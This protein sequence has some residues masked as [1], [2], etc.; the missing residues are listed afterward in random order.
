MNAEPASP[1]KLDLASHPIG[2]KY[3]TIL[4]TAVAS[5]QPNLAG[6]FLVVSWGCGTAC[7]LFAIVNL[8]TGKIWH[9]PSLILTRGVDSR[10]DSDLI[11]LNP[12]GDS[13]AATVATTYSLWKG[14]HLD[15][16]CQVLYR[17]ED[18]RPVC[19]GS[20]KKTG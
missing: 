13:F 17:E 15:P 5:G 20:N 10:A 12:V 3:R 1:G 4:R 2:H 8:K 7:Q 9:D 11:V 19:V 14:D 6:H 16:L 18:L